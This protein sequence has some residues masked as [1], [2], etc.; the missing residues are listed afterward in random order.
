MAERRPLVILDNN[1][2]AELP[3]GDTLPPTDLSG[4][5]AVFDGGSATETAPD[6]ARIDFGR[7]K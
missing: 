2:I 4:P 3:E 6:I 7:S 1:N 5:R